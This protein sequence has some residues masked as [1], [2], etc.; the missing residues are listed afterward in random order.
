M[1]DPAD[2]A[3]SNESKELILRPNCET[4]ADIGFLLDRSSNNDHS[5]QNHFLKTLAFSLGIMNDETHPSIAAFGDD[6]QLN[7]A[8]SSYENEYLFYDKLEELPTLGDSIRMDKGL[9]VAQRQMFN[10]KNG[11]RRDVPRVL[12]VVTSGVQTAVPGAEEA[13]VIA[14]EITDSGVQI[15]VINIGMKDKKSVFESI[16]SNPDYAFSVESVEQLLSPEY[17]IVLKDVICK[18]G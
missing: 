14:R 6:A 1:S 9:R 17:V 15:I 18:A 8:F 10:S 4:K 13:S 3:E 7:L 5:T 11:A 16:S 12:V 2:E